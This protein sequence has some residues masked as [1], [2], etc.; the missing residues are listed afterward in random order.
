MPTG[1]PGQDDFIAGQVTFHSLLP[2]GQG[3]RQAK[4]LRCLAEGE[5]KIPFFLALPQELS[6]L[7]PTFTTYNF[8]ETFKVGTMILVCWWW[9]I[10]NKYDKERTCTKSNNTTGQINKPPMKAQCITHC[11]AVI[12][13]LLPVKITKPKEFILLGLLQ[14]CRL[15]LRVIKLFV[16]TCQRIHK[17]SY[18]ALYAFISCTN[19]PK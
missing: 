3:L 16:T 12:K 13:T 8:T 5:A 19:A 2:N 7:L 9:K 17:W 1:R 4:C 6:V 11:I 15:S 10:K 18:K 14:S